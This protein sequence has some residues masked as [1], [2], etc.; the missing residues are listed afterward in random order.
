MSAIAPVGLACA[1]SVAQ[2]EAVE[3]GGLF[4]EFDGGIAPPDREFRLSSALI[5]DCM[6]GR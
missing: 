4:V 2:A 1:A 5:P 6:L 3:R